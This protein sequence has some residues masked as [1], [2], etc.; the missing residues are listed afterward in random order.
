MRRLKV[1]C[2]DPAQAEL[3]RRSMR[4]P[5]DRLLGA[6]AFLSSSPTRV[7][8]PADL[9]LAEELASRAARAIENARL[10]PTARRATQLRRRHPRRRLGGGGARVGR[11]DRGAA[12]RMN[13]LIQELLDVSRMEANRMRIEASPVPTTRL[14]ADVADAHRP[15]AREPARQRAQ[16]HAAGP[17]DHDR[18]HAPAGSRKTEH[19]GTIRVENEPG[20]GTTFFFTIPTV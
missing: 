19:H 5:H 13:R 15:L 4:M 8:G 2:R 6:I 7:Y 14:V 16:V 11:G 20:Q 10:H 9:R 17:P 3:R 18:R 12:K 1:A